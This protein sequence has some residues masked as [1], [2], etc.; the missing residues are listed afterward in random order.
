MK[1]IYTLGVSLLFFLGS[2]A[3]SIG[4]QTFTASGN[5]DDPTVVTVNIADITVNQ[6][7]PINSIT[8][9]NSA[10]SIGSSNCGNWYDFT[11]TKDGN[12]LISNGCASSFDGT[13]V[14][15]F[16]ILTV[17]SNDLDAFSD[18]VTIMFDLVVDYVTPTCPAP[19]ALTATN[20]SDVS[21]DVSWTT[22][23][24]SNWNIE[25]G[26]TGFTQG[27][28]TFVYN[29]TNPYTLT[30]LSANTDYDVYVQDSCGVGDVSTWISTT[31]TTLP[32][33]NVFPLNENFDSATLLFVDDN[34]NTPWVRTN[35]LAH[36]GDSSM[37]N[38]YG[39]NEIN[40]LVET[41]VLDLSSTNYPVLEFWH[42]AKTEG[43]YDDAIVEISTDGG[44]TYSVLPNSTY[45]GSGV[46]SGYFDE[47]SYSDWGTSSTTVL[48]NTMW[49]KEIFDLSGYNVANV[50]VRFKLV[51]DVSIHREGWYIDDIAVYEPTCP[52]PYNLSNAY[53]NADSVVL[54]WV[55][56]ASETMWNIEYGSF[57]FTQGTGTMVTGVT[58]TT[59]TIVGLALGSVYEFYVQADC[60]SGDTSDWVGP[61]VVTTPLLNDTTCDA[62][63]V[64]PNVMDT[65]FSNINATTQTGEQPL[66]G[67][68]YNT[69]WFKTV[70][71][72]SGHLLIAT[73]NSDFHTVVGAYAYDTLDCTDFNTFGQIAYS[74]SNSS[75]CGVFGRG[76]VEICG[77]TPGDTILFYVG[78][79][80]SSQEGIIKLTI[81]DWGVTGQ[82]GQPA[83][84]IAPACA[85][86]T[87]DLWNDLTGQATNMGT[88]KYPLNPTAIVD[89]SLL[90]TGALSISGLEVY[91]IVSNSCDADTATIPLNVA[92]M[93][94]SGTAVS[95]FQACNAGDVFLFDGLTGTIDAGGT[96]NDDTNTGLLVGNKFIAAGLPVG[97]YQFTYAVN[98]GV[99][100]PASTQITVE[101][102]D[103]TNIT[104]EGSA[105]F[106]I[107]PNPN[108]GTFYV[109]NGNTDS[110]VALEVID[111]QGK[112]VYSGTYTVAANA[113]QE[114]QLNNVVPGMY[115]VKVITNN[116]VF[117]HTVMV[118]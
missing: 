54:S 83:S 115:I 110:K 69:V 111:V 94:H 95:N 117:N 35:A 34:S 67:I 63:L 106:A 98:N 10:G 59:D 32:P 103:C 72:A 55:A 100:P 70:V 21:A 46:Y 4:T 28:G 29:V 90:N 51:T 89:D 14:T 37:F 84:T 49:K 57:G 73:C 76:S 20:M 6:G 24:A 92:T 80:S 75:I 68:Q 11:L 31:F 78:G 25:Y 77:Q 33:A 86:D 52:M 13:D 53:Q 36:S 58:G 101:L 41:G 48:D 71:P 64:E 40:I 1:K 18:G 61:I 97:Q 74:F 114:V 15:G 105:D 102:V 30:G 113:Q 96:W 44:V 60:G 8:L 19:T 45:R 93:T 91:Y 118:K 116:K 16:T 65:V 88:W 87:I 27:S 56:G 9:N 99:C 38:G 26:P 5:D 23:G 109:V 39:N 3:Q 108:N 107:Y 47:E 81:M 43:G 50:R 42:I 85:G 22:G 104:E 12:T 2:N 82:A 66:N 112:V 17:A 7:Q 62:I 79:S